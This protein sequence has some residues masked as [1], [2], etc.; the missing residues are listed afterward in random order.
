MWV[1]NRGALRTCVVSCSLE[2]AVFSLAGFA[3]SQ[4]R[5]LWKVCFAAG[6]PAVFRNPSKHKRSISPDGR[7]LG[8]QRRMWFWPS[9]RLRCQCWPV[10][11]T[12]LHMY[13]DNPPHL[14]APR[15]VLSFGPSV[16]K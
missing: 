13:C 8:V 5:G 15:R 1:A 2:L 6:G 10:T 3:L 12:E 16:K 11:H 7:M 14:W 9:A 4:H